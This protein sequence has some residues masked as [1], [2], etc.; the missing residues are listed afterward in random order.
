[1]VKAQM[2]TRIRKVL[3]SKTSL[4]A[5]LS[6]TTYRLRLSLEGNLWTQAGSLTASTSYRLY[7][8]QLLSPT[9]K[10]V[11]RGSCSV[12]MHK[13]APNHLHLITLNSSSEHL[14]LG[15]SILG[16]T[17]DLLRKFSHCFLTKLRR[18]GCPNT[19]SLHTF[20]TTSGS[21][22]AVSFLTLQPKSCGLKSLH[23][24]STSPL[25]ILLL[26]LTLL[27]KMMQTVVSIIRQVKDKTCF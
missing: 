14:T 12:G 24:W 18:Q 19:I 2:P 23:R 25:V 6:L 3:N 16:L 9:K 17:S 13:T 5:S 8:N 15:L 10:S 7:M 11:Q 27:L 20:S 21:G 1:M 22:Q 26:T 4:T